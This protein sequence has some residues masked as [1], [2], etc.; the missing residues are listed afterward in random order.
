MPSFWKLR[1]LALFT[2]RTLIFG[3]ALSCVYLGTAGATYYAQQRSLDRAARLIS[4]LPLLPRPVPATRLMVFAPHCDDETLGNAGLIQAVREAGGTVRTVIFTNG[5][6]FPAAVERET[7]RLR[8]T[9]A[10][11]VH[12]GELR[13]QESRNAMESLGVEKGGTLFLGYP[14]GGL[15]ALWNS[16]WTPETPFASVFT[17]ATASPYAQCFRPGTVYC[18]KSVVEDVKNALRQ[19]RPTMI[20]VTHPTE[21]HADHAASGAFVT[22]AL[23]EL[24]DD[25]ASAAWASRCELRYYLVH[26]GDWP[27][28]PSAK[29]K[30]NPLSPPSTMRGQDTDWHSLSLTTKQ[31][32]RK[33]NAIALYPSQTAIM[34]RF[35]SAFVTS[36]EIFGKMRPATIPMV[37][38]DAIHLDGRADE[39]DEIPPVILDPINDNLFRSMQGGA[40]LRTVYACRDK[41]NLYLRVDT[42]TDVSSRCRFYFVL[43]PF[44][45]EGNSPGSALGFTVE[46][47]SVTPNLNV[48]TRT[49]GHT[50]EVAIPLSRLTDPLGNT[51]LTRL[52]LS[53]D[54]SVAG[55]G[56]DRT[57]IRLLEIGQ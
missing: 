10:D 27:P 13:Q 5:D 46:G 53:V 55:V 26:R 47:K 56:I 19:F 51:N 50:L 38:S 39:W 1:P 22:L 41:K 30:F 44:D 24:Q 8:V 7:R 40:D 4:P 15:L 25:P 57:G 54:T 11:Y 18:G 14:D 9:A 35:L 21:D 2:L 3:A 12:F 29:G 42:R 52:S 49:G 28:A 31:S 6:G 33:A 23:R 17:G 34:E 37:D 36:N 45:R 20:T 16:H 43:R 48:K 32:E